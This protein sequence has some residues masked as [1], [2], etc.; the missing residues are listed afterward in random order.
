MIC[1]QRDGMPNVKVIWM[2]MAGALLSFQFATEAGER[3]PP[4]PP[5]QVIPEPMTDD[6]TGFN[7]IFDGKTLEDWDGDPRYWRVEDGAIVGQTTEKN[8]PK[9]NS[10]IIWRGGKPADFEIKV[11][12]RISAT[13][14]S[15]LQYRSSELPGV[16]WVLRG[17]Q[18][19]ID[20]AEWGKMFYENFAK[21]KGLELR[22][23]TAQ[24]YEERGRT[25]LALPG[26]LAHV[27]S[28]K[29]QRAIASLGNMEDLIRSMSDDWNRLHLIVRGDQMIHILNDR[30]MSIV[31]DDDKA[32][33]C[34]RGNLGMQIHVGPPMK[35]EFRNIRL[36]TLSQ[37]ATAPEQPKG[38]RRPAGG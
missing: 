23:V 29:R 1:L 10:F 24:N 5:A 36:K 33:R 28:G 4:P 38:G 31:I 37:R 27:S 16:K 15:A 6:N 20:G 17:Y 22:R 9:Y 13:G 19:D 8:L 26:Q 7:T 35:A 11:E 21:P 2:A 12:Y 18:A 3:E 25:F 34:M 14:N 32:N 30:V